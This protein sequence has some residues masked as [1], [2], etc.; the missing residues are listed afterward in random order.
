MQYKITPAQ[1]GTRPQV[2]L[3]NPK[4]LEALGEEG[5]RKMVSDHYDL[6]RQS[7]IRG[8]FPPTDEGFE[9]AKKHSADFFIQICGGPRYFDESR[10][11]P[12]MV[13]RHMPFAITQEARRIWLESY[14]MVLN[15]LDLEE[16][17]KES[18]WNYI[19]IFSIW[20]MNT[21]DNH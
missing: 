10:G 3:P 19:D 20:M 15:S 17:L 4:I 5:M 12:R 7:N 1:V 14:I 21:H 13:A 11:A 8:L 9:M 6:L 16:D 2:S 18:F